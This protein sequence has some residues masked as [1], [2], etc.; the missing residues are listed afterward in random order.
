MKHLQLY[1]IFIHVLLLVFLLA[2]IWMGRDYYERVSRDR[3][4]IHFYGPNIEKIGKE[5]NLDVQVETV[6]DIFRAYKE[7]SSVLD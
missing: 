5:F 2:T 3:K 1:G 6:E 7:I 4:F